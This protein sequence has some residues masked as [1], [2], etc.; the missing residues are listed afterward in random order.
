VENRTRGVV[1]ERSVINSRICSYGTCGSGGL[2]GKR[3]SSIKTE[4]ESQGQ[5]A[6]GEG[7][8]IDPKKSPCQDTWAV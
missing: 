8:R 1:G 5:E 4:T 6:T 2:E 3:K 7:E